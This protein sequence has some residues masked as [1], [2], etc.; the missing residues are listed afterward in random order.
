MSS[1]H[2]FDLLNKSMIEKFTVVVVV[3]L[4]LDLNTESVVVKMYNGFRNFKN[5]KKQIKFGA[6]KENVEK[7]FHQFLILSAKQLKFL[8]VFN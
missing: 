5:N 7:N 8:K 6:Q 1:R 2:R 4:L 3:A